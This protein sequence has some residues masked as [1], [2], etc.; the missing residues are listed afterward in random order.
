MRCGR[1]SKVI[2]EKAKTITVTKSNAQRFLMYQLLIL[3]SLC[4]LASRGAHA[5]S[6]KRFPRHDRIGVTT[7]FPNGG[8]GDNGFS[9]TKRSLIANGQVAEPNEFPFMAL[10][11]PPFDEFCGGTLIASDIII[12]AAVCQNIFQQVTVS[13][14]NFDT[15]STEG[16]AIPVTVVE[17]RRHPFYEF[18]EISQSDLLVSPTHPWFACFMLLACDPICSHAHPRLI[19]APSIAD[20]EAQ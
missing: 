4:S 8:H 14:Y 13:A 16:G 15:T 11:R 1:G 3:L 6:S 18:F 10:G 12:T 20:L 7:S 9:G 19:R 17:Q 2:L 5:L